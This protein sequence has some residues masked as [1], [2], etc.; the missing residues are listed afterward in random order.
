MGL[1][2]GSFNPAHDGHRTISL[3]ALRRLELDQVWWLVSPQN[4]LK[5]AEGMASLERRL[6][7]ARRCAAHPRIV[8]SDIENALGTRYTAD[9]L[10]ALKRRYLHTA[11]VWIMGADNLAQLPRWRDWEAI[12]RAMPIAIFNRP[13]YAE[14]ALTGEAA[15]RFRAYRVSAA[16]ADRLVERRPPAWIFFWESHHTGSATRLRRELSRRPTAVAIE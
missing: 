5:P 10:A 3:L 2:G 11:F 1:L 12:Y 16:Q 9:T 8:V 15:R 6:A 7:A 13:S 14:E 4:P